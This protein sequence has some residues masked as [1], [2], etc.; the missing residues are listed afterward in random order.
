M[1]EELAN[2]SAGNDVNGG[3]GAEEEET[4]PPAPSPS[5]VTVETESETPV[6]I[7]ILREEKGRDSEAEKEVDPGN[8][9]KEKLSEPPVDDLGKLLAGKDENDNSLKMEK[10]VKEKNVEKESSDKKVK[11][12]K[13]VGG[14]TPTVKMIPTPPVK[15]GHDSSSGASK[16]V[17][18]K[19]SQP[20][21][22]SKVK[23]EV[24]IKEPNAEKAVK[25]GEEDGDKR[26][27]DKVNLEEKKTEVN[28]T[29]GK[30]CVSMWL[31]SCW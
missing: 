25:P 15:E 10:E 1:D 22:R 20:A 3:I 26:K 9:E 16:K 4:F 8:N 21:K 12:E 5:P 28:D 6:M 17:D 23:K 2:L 7:E 30:V 14:L 29:M 13:E 24:R 27:S 11:L 19:Q 18:R 31:F